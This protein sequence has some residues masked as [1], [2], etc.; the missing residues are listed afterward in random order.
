M[1]MYW[2]NGNLWSKV[3]YV[4]GKLHGPWEEYYTNS[5]VS[6]KGNYLN[7]ELHG[8]SERYYQ[9]GKLK[10]IRYYIT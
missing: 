8:P 2:D 3:N 10:E 6:I 7:G 9:N 1:G 5:K 4:N